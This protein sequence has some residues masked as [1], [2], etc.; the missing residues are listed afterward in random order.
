[1]RLKLSDPIRDIGP[2]DPL[3]IAIVFDRKRQVSDQIYDA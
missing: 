1:M 2:D 3:P